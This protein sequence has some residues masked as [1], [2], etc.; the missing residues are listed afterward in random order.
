MVKKNENSKV[1]D[2]KSIAEISAMLFANFVAL[3]NPD[4]F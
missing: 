4:P 3:S 2:R 1:K